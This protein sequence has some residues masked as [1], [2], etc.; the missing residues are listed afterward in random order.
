MIQR[1]DAKKYAYKDGFI[2]LQQA[3]DMCGLT[4]PGMRH[5]LRGC[6]GDMAAAIAMGSAVSGSRYT[7]RGRSIRVEDAARMVGVSR[8]YMSE[9]IKRHGGNMDA[10]MDAIMSEMSIAECEILEALGIVDE[11]PV[12]APAPKRVPTTAPTPAPKPERKPVPK[13]ERKPV[14]KPEPLPAQMTAAPVAAEEKKRPGVPELDSKD[15]RILR[16]INVCIRG[17][18]TLICEVEELD[19]DSIVLMDDTAQRL[20]KVRREMFDEA[21]DWEGM[22]K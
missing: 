22:A 19:N 17:L 8:G 16:C 2:T 14:P 13:P 15:K 5:R 1:R 12:A 4:C 11:E 18:K 9:T 10:A 21:I 20:Q 3:A 7:C 6:G